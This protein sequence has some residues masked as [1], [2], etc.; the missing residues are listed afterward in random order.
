MGSAEQRALMGGIFAP[1]KISRTTQRSDKQQTILDSPGR[2][3]YKAYTF[4]KIEV[5]GQV[6]LRS[7]AKYYAFW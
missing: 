3:L 4:L 5:T 1:P 2:E 6:K 7:N